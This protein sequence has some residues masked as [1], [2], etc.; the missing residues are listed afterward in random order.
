MI[1][2]ELFLFIDSEK[3]VVLNAVP[4]KGVQRCLPSPTRVLWCSFSPDGTRLASC[5]SDGFINIWNVDTCQVYRRF[6]SNVG[7]SSAACWWSDRF[8]FV[9][10]FID[11][12]P[13]L[14]K[15]PVDE[16]FEVT[17]TQ[18]QSVSLCPVISEFSSFSR[19]LDFSEGYLSFECGET[20]PVKVLDVNRSGP[21]ESVILPGIRPK[22]EIAVSSGACFVLGAGVWRILSLEKERSS[23]NYIRRLCFLSYY[24]R[25]HIFGNVVSVLI[26]N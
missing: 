4:L 17:T 1:A 7:T 21:P 24:L 10:C 5:T 6:K 15:Y 18:G 8:L 20:K 13:S 23:T 11:E 3:L 2:D 9:F 16:N 25:K 19:I 14:S 26:R 12:T 22:M